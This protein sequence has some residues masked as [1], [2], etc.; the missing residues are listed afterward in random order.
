M[1]NRDGY[2][3]NAEYDILY[4]I[5]EALMCRKGLIYGFD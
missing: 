2:N 3:V 1:I 4:L 5:S